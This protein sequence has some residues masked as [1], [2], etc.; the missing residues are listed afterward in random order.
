MAIVWDCRR[1]ARQH[2]LVAAAKILYCCSGI[3][4]T[5]KNKKCSGQFIH[6]KRK[7]QFFGFSKQ[8]A[9]VV[10][11]RYLHSFCTRRNLFTC[12]FSGMRNSFTL[13]SIVFRGRNTL[14]SI[15]YGDH[16]CAHRLGYT[17]NVVTNAAGHVCLPLGHSKHCGKDFTNQKRLI[18][19]RL[20]ENCDP[21]FISFN[22]G[23]GQYGRS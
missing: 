4:T 17:N 6:T 13:C 16:M 12:I 23:L 20:I 21:Q 8:E 19:F 10:F 11:W 18:L 5:P 15:Q 22:L 9:I 1:L 2:T 3:A 7:A 14:T